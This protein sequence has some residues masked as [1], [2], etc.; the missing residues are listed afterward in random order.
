MR[1]YSIISLLVFMAVF[2]LITVSYVKPWSYINEL[3][4]NDPL[5]WYPYVEWYPLK[6][7]FFGGM[8]VKYTN[9]DSQAN[10]K[11]FIQLC[12]ASLAFAI[13]AWIGSIVMIIISIADIMEKKIPEICKFLG[14]IVFLFSLLSFS[15]YLG[16]PSAKIKDCRMSFLGS[17]D[18]D[19]LPIYQQR[20][21]GTYID[22]NRQYER[23]VEYKFGLS[24]GLISIVIACAVSLFGSIYNLFFFNHQ[25]V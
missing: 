9:F 5:K 19:T 25:N 16:T 10:L 1:K 15:I 18:C 6:A 17:K 22:Y 8:T 3:S 13:L 23:E 24:A 11:Y 12:N 14:W 21:I 4:T 20:L 2:A 7:T